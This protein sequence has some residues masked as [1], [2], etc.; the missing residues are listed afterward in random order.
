M[1]VQVRNVGGSVG[2]SLAIGIVSAMP[3]CGGSE[4]LSRT[5]SA[6]TALGDPLPGLDQTQL[7][8]FAEAKDVFNEVEAVADGL[9]PVF[10]ERAC[11]NCHNVGASGGSGTQFE[12][13]AGRLVNNTFDSLTA[14]GGQLFDLFSVT[15]LPASERTA[16]PSCALPPNGE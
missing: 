9:G 10:N 15:S 1:K 14:Q 13:R 2:I 16:I 12:V 6:L 8:R 4:E 5:E 7:A 11:G 3:A